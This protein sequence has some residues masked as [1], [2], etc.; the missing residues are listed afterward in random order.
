MHGVKTLA[1]AL[2]EN[3][4]VTEINLSHNQIR[5]E[6]ASALADALKVNTSVTN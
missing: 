5:D 2:K 6:G 3:T 1:N 4:T